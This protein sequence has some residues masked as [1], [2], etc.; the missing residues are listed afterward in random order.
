VEARVEE[1]QETVEEE[2][3]PYKRC[4]LREHYTCI[5]TQVSL[6]KSDL[7]DVLDTRRDPM[8]LV[9]HCV[10]QNKVHSS[11]LTAQ[12]VSIAGAIARTQ[13]PRRCHLA[14]WTHLELH[15]DI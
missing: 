11:A 12:D 10:D 3:K 9:R 7:V 2:R 4:R 15:V 14:F 5:D 13:L 1:Q 8:W 6:E